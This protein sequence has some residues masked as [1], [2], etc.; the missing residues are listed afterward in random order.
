MTQSKDKRQGWLADLKVGDEVILERKIGFF[1]WGRSILPI[2]KITPTG[3]ITVRF[4]SG[5][6]VVCSPNGQ[7]MGGSYGEGL[8]ELTPELADEVR[9]ENRKRNLINK[10]KILVTDDNLKHFNSK[11]LDEILA[12]L[13]SKE[14]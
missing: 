11:E 12:I 9:E 7:I 2:T 14:K 4:S 13:K 10:V 5:A 1:E 6:E 8:I 3:R